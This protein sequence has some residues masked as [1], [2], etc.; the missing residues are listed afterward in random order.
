VGNKDDN[1]RDLV[2]RRLILKV[3]SHSF[4]GHGTNI[5]F[6]DSK[7]IVSSP[8]ACDTGALEGIP[9]LWELFLMRAKQEETNSRKKSDVGHRSI[10]LM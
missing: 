10:T 3:Y 2:F 4:S 9:W 8:E 1:L 5:E 7:E 6:L